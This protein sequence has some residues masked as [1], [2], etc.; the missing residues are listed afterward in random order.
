[1]V[2][3]D[4]INERRKHYGHLLQPDAFFQD[5]YAQLEEQIIGLEEFL[6]EVQEHIKQDRLATAEVMTKCDF[7]S[8]IDDFE[9]ELMW[10]NIKEK[11]F[12]TRIQDARH[13]WIWVQQS[14]YLKKIASELSDVQRWND[15]IEVIRFYPNWVSTLLHPTA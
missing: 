5:Q 7:N 4:N 11:T 10:T 6:T 9:Q 14:L 12:E 13:K 8:D 1:M 15:E 3:C 2:G